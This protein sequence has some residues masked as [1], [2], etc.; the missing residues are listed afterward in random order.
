MKKTY[1]QELKEMSNEKLLDKFQVFDFDS[2]FCEASAEDYPAIKAEL[3][4]R[5]KQPLTDGELRKEAIKAY[6]D[7]SSH[8]QFGNDYYI[9]L[10]N[11][12]R[13]AF[14]KGMKRARDFKPEEKK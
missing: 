3:L 14:I 6:P 11:M 9:K 5:L 13:E 12:G 1:E 4:S 8:E 7:Q 10:I 2:P